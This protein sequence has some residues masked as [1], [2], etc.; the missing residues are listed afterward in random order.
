MEFGKGY[1][2]TFSAGVEREWVITNGIGGYCGS[3]IINACA[4]MHHAYLVASLHAPVERY[5]VLNKID[6]SITIGD[7][8]YSFATNQRP[9]GWNEEGQKYLQ[10]F[11]YDELPHFVYQAEG[12]FINKT[13]SFEWEKNTIA[14]GYDIMNGAKEAVYEITPFFTYRDHSSRVE[15]SDLKFKT[16]L[17]GKKTLELVPKKN[18]DV[19]IKFYA[20]NGKFVENEEKYD[21][22]MELQTEINTG[23]E[24]INNSYTPY[25]VVVKLAPFEHKKIS[26]ICSIEKKFEKDA[27]VT[28]EKEMERIKKIKENA[29]Y[30]DEFANSLVQ[31]TSL[32]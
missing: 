18:K 12:T 3:T 7:K 23:G 6:E 30:T 25:K 17:T 5:A 15:K 32:L 28:I 8:T 24:P 13:L 22:D 31:Q 11:V 10:R 1:W 19:T 9:G 26:V 21:H 14:I 4:R 29:G 20:S 27:F 16:E 2:K